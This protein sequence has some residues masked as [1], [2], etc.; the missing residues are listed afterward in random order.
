MLR[1]ERAMDAP[2]YDAIIW[3]L[4]QIAAHQ[5]AINQDQRVL[6]ERLVMAIERL[7]LTQARIETLLARV[8]RTDEPNGRDA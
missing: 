2:E 6:N 1:K 3:H 4:V 8:L 7:D 5:D